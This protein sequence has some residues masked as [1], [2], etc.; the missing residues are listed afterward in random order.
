MKR[1]SGRLL[2]S[3]IAVGVIGFAVAYGVVLA[4]APDDFAARSGLRGA[5]KGQGQAPPA[6]DADMLAAFD[7]AIRSAMLTGV[8]VAALVSVVLSWL[9]VRQ[10][11][12][13]LSQVREAARSLA[14]GDYGARIPIPQEV[15]LAALAD[16]V[17]QLAR[18]LEDSELRR[19]RLIGEVAHEMRTP[20]TVIDG[21]VEGMID[22]VFEADLERLGKLSAETR[23]LRRL[24]EDLSA[25]SRAEEG[26]LDLVKSRVDLTRLTRETAERIRVQF[27]DLE[28][29]LEVE[30]GP[31]AL[32]DADPDRLGQVITNLLGNAL[33][34]CSPGGQ[35]QIATSIADGSALVTVTDNGRGIAA[36]DLERIFERFYRGE[37]PPGRSGYKGSGVGLTIARSIVSA[38]GGTLTVS[39]PGIAQGTT[40]RLAL[41]SA[42]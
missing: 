7:A 14:G 18:A 4:T 12:R 25:L 29:S 2:V 30:E 16:D 5:G 6:Q 11:L 13:P 39:S 41:P 20:L 37:Q 32:V 22:G 27:E 10:V 31:E 42:I 33:M 35:V 8:I 34:A 24:A 26:R 15:E 17:N 36:E 1:L 3:H 19:V 21:T 38:H 40:F 28:V 23:V 9:I